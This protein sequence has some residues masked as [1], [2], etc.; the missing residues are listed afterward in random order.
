[1]LKASL[2]KASDAILVEPEAPL[3]L[4]LSLPDV[5]RSDETLVDHVLA[6]FGERERFRGES[7]L[8]LQWSGFSL[9][10]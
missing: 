8:A 9:P 6:K 7:A 5:A 1:M 2:Q 4:F 10:R 3:P